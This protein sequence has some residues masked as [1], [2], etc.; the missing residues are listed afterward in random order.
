MR[1]NHHFLTRRFLPALLAALTELEMLGCACNSAGQ[2]YA[3]VRQG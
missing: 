3:R 2:Q 1:K